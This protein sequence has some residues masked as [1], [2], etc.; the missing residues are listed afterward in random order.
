MGFCHADGDAAPD[1]STLPETPCPSR[2]EV[3][4]LRSGTP[5]LCACSIS[6]RS[7]F[8]LGELSYHP[9][10]T[11]PAPGALPSNIPIECWEATGPPRAPGHPCHPE[12]GPPPP[13]CRSRR[14][15]PAVPAATT[16]WSPAGA[17]SGTG[18]LTSQRDATSGLAAG[19]SEAAAQGP[20]LPT[21]C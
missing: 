14:R 7:L 15:E 2:H 8:L 21:R 19:S 4:L 13:W 5:A 16:R 9:R 12:R 10:L 20:K 6:L 1:S 3:R 11:H 17:A 18:G